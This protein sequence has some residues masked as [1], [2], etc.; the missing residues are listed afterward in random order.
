MLIL[1]ILLLLLNGLCIQ[2]RLL[3]LHVHD[4]LDRRRGVLD[5]VGIVSRIVHD[6][7]I[8]SALRLI[9]A[10]SLLLRLLVRTD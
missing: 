6:R 4:R 9:I 8:A 3:L 5:G 10:L 1:L 7:L 2:H